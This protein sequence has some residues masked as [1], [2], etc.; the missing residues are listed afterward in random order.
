V[1][2]SVALARQHAPNTVRHASAPPL[3]AGVGVPPLSLRAL[4]GAGAEAREAPLPK[5]PRASQEVP[6]VGKTMG[7][8]VIHH[9]L[10]LAPLAP[11]AL[12]LAS[13]GRGAERMA[14]IVRVKHPVGTPRGRYDEHNSKFPSVMKPRFIKPVGESQTSEGDAC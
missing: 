1:P 5:D 8:C 10:N 6:P 7:G 12:T 13:V 4:L 14:V 2:R 11:R 9:S 3:A